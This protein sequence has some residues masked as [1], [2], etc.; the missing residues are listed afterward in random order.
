MVKKLVVNEARPDMDNRRGGGFKKG[1][2]RNSGNRGNSS[3]GG[4]GKR[5]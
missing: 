3:K 2:N 1:G 4:G 5:W